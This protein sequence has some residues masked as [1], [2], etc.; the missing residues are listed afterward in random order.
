MTR[1]NQVT[2]PD[3]LFLV[4][5]S[6]STP[7]NHSTTELLSAQKARVSNRVI[8]SRLNMANPR[9]L[10]WGLH[11]EMAKWFDAQ[12]YVERYSPFGAMRRKSFP[13]EVGRSFS[14][15]SCPLP[16]RCKV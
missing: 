3:R 8:C 4:V 13:F 2:I 16:Q 9:L 12:P 6:L 1:S 7:V 11:Q 14:D 5:G 15:L 10:A